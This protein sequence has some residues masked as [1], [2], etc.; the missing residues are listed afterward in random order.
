VKVNGECVTLLGVRIDPERDRVEVDGQ[1][2]F[3]RGRHRYILLHKPAGYLVSTHDPHHQ[4]TIFDLLHGIPERLFPVGRLD[5][6]TEGAL[7]L[8]NDGEFAFR[9][10]HPRYTVEKRYLALVRGTPYEAAIQRLSEGVDLAGRK[11]A[12]AWVRVIG[13]EEGDALLEL[14]LHEGMN[15]QVKR[16]CQAIHH[17]VR[18]LR[19]VDFAGIGVERLKSGAWRDLTEE[20]VRRLKECVGL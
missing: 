19:R 6:D 2:L 1:R 15:R 12:P 4:R 18:H 17:P 14:V 7:L 10:S 3:S 16:M 8:T 13:I 20:E 5:L 9:L 11:T